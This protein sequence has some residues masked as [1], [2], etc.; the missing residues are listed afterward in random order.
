MSKGVAIA[1]ICVFVLAL[2]VLHQFV[3]FMGWQFALG[4]L[5]GSTVYQLGYYCK[6]GISY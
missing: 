1:I 2:A 5:F 4:V 3:S 6:T